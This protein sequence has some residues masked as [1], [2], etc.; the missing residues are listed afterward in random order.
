[1]GNKRNCRGKRKLTKASQKEENT[2][3]GDNIFGTGNFKL[4]KSSSVY[5][6]FISSFSLQQDNGL[7]MPGGEDLS[8]HF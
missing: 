8:P 3:V 5:H 2:T 6:T 4:P 1:M 7:D